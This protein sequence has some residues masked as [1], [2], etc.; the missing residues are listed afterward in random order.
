MGRPK[1]KLCEDCGLTKRLKEFRPGRKICKD[2]S[3][4]ARHP[5]RGVK[6]SF[7]RPALIEA[8]TIRE[9]RRWWISPN[10]GAFEE[11]TAKGSR[12]TK[13]V[14][15]DQAPSA[16]RFATITREVFE[17][18]HY[19]QLCT[20]LWS[21]T[22]RT[23]RDP[24]DNTI[25]EHRRYMTQLPQTSLG[26]QV[27]RASNAS[28]DY[29]ER[30]Y[31]NQLAGSQESIRTSASPPLGYIADHVSSQAGRLITQTKV[32]QIYKASKG[33]YNAPALSNSHIRYVLGKKS[34]KGVRELGN[35]VLTQILGQMVPSQSGNVKYL[36][37]S[38]WET[39]PGGKGACE[40]IEI[41][42]PNKGCLIESVP[43]QIDKAT[44]KIKNHQAWKQEMI[45]ARSTESE[46]LMA[47][48]LEEL[49]SIPVNENDE[50]PYLP[51]DG[52]TEY[53]EQ[54]YDKDY[55]G[56]HG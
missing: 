34:T 51:S 55:F 31:T 49:E 8:R 2:C 33:R 28:R 10:P 6:E 43:L 16:P 21:R 7:I 20:E 18:S 35:W 48:V 54:T 37:N 52:S 40:A 39:E 25:Y 41:E 47:T 9:T 19:E 26:S 29:A 30:D 56:R 42:G 38:W 27:R 12:R 5:D 23:P 32:G 53:S 4:K 13:V 17:P 24:Q 45:K 44:G 11:Y 46:S 15:P 22:G 36:G 14:Y 50:Q 3:N 1:T